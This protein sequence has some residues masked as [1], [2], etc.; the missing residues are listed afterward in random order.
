MMASVVHRIQEMGVEV[1][2]IPGECTGLCQPVDVGFNTDW[3]IDGIATGS[4]TV[5]P[6]RKVVA[7]WIDA[8]MTAMRNK[9]TIVKNAWKKTGYEWFQDWGI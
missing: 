1:I 7:E 4:T 3:M 8:V 5:T 2:H 9:A 6:T